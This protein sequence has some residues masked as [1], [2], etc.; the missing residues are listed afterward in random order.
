MN[1]NKSDRSTINLNAA[2]PT[3]AKKA[4]I[5]QGAS[6]NIPLPNYLKKSLPPSN[7]NVKALTQAS[8][9]QPG[10][11]GKFFAKMGEAKTKFFATLSRMWTSIKNSFQKLLPHKQVAPQQPQVKPQQQFIQQSKPRTEPV[12]ELSEK[13]LK[14]I[15]RQEDQSP[16]NLFSGAKTTEEKLKVI[17]EMRNNVPI[18]EKAKDSVKDDVPI[19][20]KT[21]KPT[22]E[23][24]AD[25]EP[26][27]LTNFD[28][29]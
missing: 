17:E 1:V 2:P 20:N 15:N 19:A 14:D 22:D 23:K 8:K 5:Y 11:V 16:V 4:N 7:E 6:W 18:S 28:D 25:Y 9:A 13:I 27:D 12:P 3:S 21:Q 10:T 26:I 24:K 29:I